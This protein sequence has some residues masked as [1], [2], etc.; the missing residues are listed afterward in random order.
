MFCYKCLKFTVTNYNLKFYKKKYIQLY[1][2]SLYNHVI[3]IHLYYASLH[4]TISVCIKFLKNR[5]FFDL[6]LVSFL[7]LEKLCSTSVDVSRAY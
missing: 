4:C 2:A 7:Y 1:S 5:T 6:E 3:I